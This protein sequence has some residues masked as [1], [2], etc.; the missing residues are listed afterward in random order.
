MIE[1]LPS[2]LRR[3]TDC[4]NTLS[5]FSQAT[6]RTKGISVFRGVTPCLAFVVLWQPLAGIFHA[7]PFWP[8]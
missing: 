4:R 2:W 6:V 1:C 8:L 5:G 3:S 7:I